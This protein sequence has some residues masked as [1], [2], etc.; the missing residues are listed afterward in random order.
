MARS[1]E[2]DLSIP[3]DGALKPCCWCFSVGC[4]AI[5]SASISAVSAL[6]DDC[7]RTDPIRLFAGIQLIRRFRTANWR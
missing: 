2:A 4:P 7:A 6:C 3:R 5:L 1:R